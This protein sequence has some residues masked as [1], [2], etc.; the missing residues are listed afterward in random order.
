M[1]TLHEWLYARQRE[2]SFSPEI[3]DATVGGLVT[4]MCKDSSVGGPGHLAALVV[5][6]TYVDDQGAVVRLSRE[7]DE[8][9]LEHYM[10]SYNTAGARMAVLRR[11]SFAGP[12]DHTSS[13]CTAP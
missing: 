13:C 7:A 6:L 3:G 9:A 4:T 2:L 12:Q 5:A 10:C 11:R 8:E 1:S